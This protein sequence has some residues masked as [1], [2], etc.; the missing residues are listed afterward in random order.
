LDAVFRAL[1]PGVAEAQLRLS[2]LV[3]KIATELDLA[4]RLGLSNEL[5]SRPP[6]GDTQSIHRGMNSLDR[7]CFL[8]DRRRTLRRQVD[9]L[10]DE[11]LRANARWTGRHESGNV[12][13]SLRLH[14]RPELERPLLLFQ[15]SRL[16]HSLAERMR[17]SLEDADQV[18]GRVHV[19]KI[20]PQLD[21]GIGSV[22]Q[23]LG[24]QVENDVLILQLRDLVENRTL[25]LSRFQLGDRGGQPLPVSWP[26]LA[27]ERRLL[28]QNGRD[29]LVREQRVAEQLCLL[30]E[31]S[32][33]Q[34]KLRRFGRQ[35]GIGR[36]CRFDRRRLPR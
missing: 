21:R 23:L 31:T 9:A 8:R 34:V 6:G 11:C 27:L 30:P 20:D 22:P 3:A 2:K 13:V 35:G 15:I 36:G 7:I 32:D 4:R 16:S 33:C 10:L 1:L 14:L 18:I 12:L 17:Q 25:L 29:L 26:Q 5:L 19:R 28:R 24:R